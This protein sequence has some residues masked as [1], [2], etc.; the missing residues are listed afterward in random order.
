MLGVGTILLILKKTGL[1]TT[2]IISS[3]VVMGL[4][5]PDFRH[6]NICNKILP[7]TV[8]TFIATSQIELL[9]A[10]SFNLSQHKEIE[11]GVG[12]LSRCGIIVDVYLN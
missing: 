11:L 10:T 7:Q 12:L 9:K 8:D 3:F 6:Y 5:S 1:E 2:F 4:H